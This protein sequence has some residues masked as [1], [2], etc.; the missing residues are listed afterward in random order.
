MSIT[1]N[2]FKSG[3][4]VRYKKVEFG[5]S[6]WNWE[7]FEGEVIEGGRG[8]VTFVKCTKPSAVQKHDPK[9]IGQ[10]F[11]LIT[12][13]LELVESGDKVMK[14]K[15]I[16]KGDVLRRT[17]TCTDGSVITTEGTVTR[18]TTYDALSAGGV[19][20][21]HW[22][23]DNNSRTKIELVSRPEKPKKMWEK[24]EVGHSII[25]KDADGELTVFT[26][27]EED[28]WISIYLNNTDDY[29]VPSG[30][31]FRGNE[32]IKNLLTAAEKRGDKLSHVAQGW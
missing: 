32:S 5:L 16:E 24:A 3:D 1:V 20:I 14:F 19:S 25:R 28:K 30:S 26:K 8:H 29:F 18:V 9:Y 21:V 6:G 31:Y 27:I 10:E 12:K 4:K 17:V 22:S 13:N 23:D 7:G 11:H 15:D 2:S